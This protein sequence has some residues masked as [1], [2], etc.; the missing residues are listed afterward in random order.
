MVTLTTCF[1]LFKLTFTQVWGVNQP[2]FLNWKRST[3]VSQRN[4]DTH[5]WI[6]IDFAVQIQKWLCLIHSIF[7]LLFIKNQSLSLD[8]LPIPLYMHWDVLLF[9]YFLGFSTKKTTPHTK[10]IRRWIK[11]NWIEIIMWLWNVMRSKECQQKHSVS[12]MIY[13][14]R[15]LSI[16]KIGLIVDDRQQQQQKQTTSNN[17]LYSFIETICG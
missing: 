2:L 17:N 1:S 14:M 6:R 3:D 12:I 5:K 13:L 15:K 4:I 8:W 11:V 10:S 9:V 7:M 16:N